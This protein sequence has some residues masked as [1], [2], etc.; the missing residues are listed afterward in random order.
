[1][2]GDFVEVRIKGET[3]T[4][5]VPRMLVSDV[6]PVVTEIP[7]PDE[8]YVLGKHE[9]HTAAFSLSDEKELIK[10]S[11]ERDQTAIA[12]MLQKGRCR[13]VTRGTPVFI[14]DRSGDF[15]KVRIKGT[16]DA[17]WIPANIVSDSPP[18]PDSTPIATSDST[19]ENAPTLAATPRPMTE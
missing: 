9:G 17:V 19:L 6:A 10:M 8:R 12:A 5:W 4:V 1:Y 3:D 16:T 13:L 11:D 14:T 7:S 15:V 2:Y 18:I